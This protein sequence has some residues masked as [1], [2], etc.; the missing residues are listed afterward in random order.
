MN[1]FK[2]HFPHAFFIIAILFSITF[3][4]IASH[5]YI[6]NERIGLM[7]KDGLLFRNGEEKPFSGIVVDTLDTKVIEYYVLNGYKHGDFV[8]YSETGQIEI[9]GNIV[10]NKNEGEWKYFYSNG[11]LESEGAFHKD[12]ST[13]KWKWYYPNG[14]LK[15]VGFFIND[16]KVGT[17][18]FYDE[19]GRVINECTFLNDE[20][21]VI[22]N[23]KT[24]S[25]I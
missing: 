22:R 8:V 20:L 13:G 23:F 9:F 10:D 7:S 11:Q 3:I 14:Q 4:V 1:S 25:H 15:A 12:K 18:K 6:K 2:K 21:R 19:V 5:S 16:E 24:V 17:W